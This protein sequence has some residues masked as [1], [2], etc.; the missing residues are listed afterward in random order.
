MAGEE[1]PAW[2]ANIAQLLEQQQKHIKQLETRLESKA[3]RV[4]ARHDDS[5][6]DGYGSDASARSERSYGSSNGSAASNL[7]DYEFVPVRDSNPHWGSRALAASRDDEPKRHDLYGNK[8]YDQLCGGRHEGGGALGWSLEYAEALSLHLYSANEDARDLIEYLPRD[9]LVGRH[10]D[11][12]RVGPITA[13]R[14]HEAT[15]QRKCSTHGAGSFPSGSS[16]FS[17]DSWDSSN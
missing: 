16:A 6:S 4:S 2:A 10:V 7:S 5:E 9:V 14:G 17:E 11:H 12:H 15:G 3:A 8:T 1:Q 13:G